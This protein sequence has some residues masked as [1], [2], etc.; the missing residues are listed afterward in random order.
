MWSTSFYFGNFLGS[1]IAGFIVE[2]W[3]F[4]NASMLYW[5]VVLLTTI[6][7][8]GELAYNVKNKVNKRNQEYSE[9]D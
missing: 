9:I 3:G 8:Y 1:T 6:M 5:I 2:A 7:D 4:R